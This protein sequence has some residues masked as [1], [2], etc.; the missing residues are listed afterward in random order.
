MHHNPSFLFLSLSHIHTHVVVQSVSCVQ[1]F[2]TPWTAANQALLSITN[3]WSLL[4]LMSIETEMPS[5]HLDL[6]RP[7]L[8]LPSIL[9]RIRVFSQLA[10]CI[11]WPKH[12]HN[13]KSALT[14]TI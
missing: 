4:K 7:L 8:L 2:A 10:L 9:P 13:L 12:I 1:L 5:N 3:S 14:S 11:K 6:C